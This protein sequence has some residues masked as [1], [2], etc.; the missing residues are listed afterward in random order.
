MSK[1][2]LAVLLALATPAYA[3]TAVTAPTAP[4]VPATVTVSPN[5]T[6]ALAN[7]TTNRIFIDQ[8]GNN[9]DVNMTQD[10]S[11]NKAGSSA[12]PVYLRGADQ[13][14]ITRQI[15]NNNEIDLEGD[16]ILDWTEVDPF[17]EGYV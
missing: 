17:S 7:P 6:T 11:G 10:G 3:A 14:I 13:K 4:T 16:S 15:G 9:P 5:A 2:Y 12:R 8:A 1:I